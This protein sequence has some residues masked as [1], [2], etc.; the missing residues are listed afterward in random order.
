MACG[1]PVVC[2]NS[3]SLPEVVG[4][5][6]LLVDPTD[7]AGLSEALRRVLTDA[8]LRADLAGRSLAQAK[9]FSW[10]KAAAELV[11]VYRELCDTPGS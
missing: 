8:A 9:R 6:G 1:T 11:A 2:S 7:T 3:S 5:A 4:E 10:A